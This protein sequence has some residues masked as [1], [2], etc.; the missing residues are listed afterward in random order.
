ML[1]VGLVTDTAKT[2]TGDDALEAFTFRSADNVD[3][4]AFLEHLDGEDLT[5][6]LLVTLLE[7]AE[8]SEVAFGGGVGFGEVAFH[9]LRGVALFLLA[10]SELDS[11][12]AIFLNS[13]HLCNNTRTSF[14]NSARN[15][16]S[17][18]IKKTGHSDFLSD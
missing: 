10:K 13:S 7:A 5:V 12:I 14:N 9:S 17:V 18:G 3:E 11:L 2:V 1:T 16:L 4:L 15:L 6:F 8:L